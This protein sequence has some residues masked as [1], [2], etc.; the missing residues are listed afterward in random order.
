VAAVA[1]SFDAASRLL[2]MRRERER[3]RESGARF[4]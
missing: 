1:S 4:D 3:E 2:R